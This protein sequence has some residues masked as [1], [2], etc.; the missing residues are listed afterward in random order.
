MSEEIIEC[1]YNSQHRIIRHRM[2]YHIVKCK[3][4]YIGIPLETCPFNAMHLYKK[5]NKLI[6]L[7]TCPDYHTSMAE[8]YIREASVNLK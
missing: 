2:P 7:E 8:S 1:P 5:E 6:H 4:N 3:K